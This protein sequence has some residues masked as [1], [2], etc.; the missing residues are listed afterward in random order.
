MM[1]AFKQFTFCKTAGDGYWS[2]AVRDVN[3]THMRLA[4][5]SDDG[6]FGEL[7][8]YFNTEFWDVDALGLI[9]TDTKF[10]KQ[11]KQI[12]ARQFGFTANE[13]KGLCYSEQGMQGNNYVSFD[14][15]GTALINKFRDLE[16]ACLTA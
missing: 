10:E 12:L 11:L 14:V 5:T 6:E 9:Y 16:S 13:L 7:R 8:V 1:I 3:L 2:N 4:Y 15:D